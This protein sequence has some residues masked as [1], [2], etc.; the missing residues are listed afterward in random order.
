[1]LVYTCICVCACP[2]YVL[3]KVYQI[4]AEASHSSRALASVNV[5]YWM[6][7]SL[8]NESVAERHPLRARVHNKREDVM[9][10]AEYIHA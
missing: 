5:L 4:I 3:M 10:P 9:Y 2:K 8:P 6:L 7:T 1:M